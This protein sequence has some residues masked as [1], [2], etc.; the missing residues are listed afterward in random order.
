MSQLKTGTSKAG[1][2]GARG[3]TRGVADEP[4][5]RFDAVGPVVQ[6]SRLGVVLTD[7]AEATN[8]DAAAWSAFERLISV[9]VEPL[10]LLEELADL[11]TPA[12]AGETHS[13]E[14]FAAHLYRVGRAVGSIAG[15]LPPRGRELTEGNVGGCCCCGSHSTAGHD[16]KVPEIHYDG[17]EVTGRPVAQSAPGEIFNEWA[18]TTLLVAAAAMAMD[19]PSGVDLTVDQATNTI[20]TLA[21]HSA[22]LGRMVRGHDEGGREGLLGEL[23]TARTAGDLKWAAAN[24]GSGAAP[25]MRTMSGGAPGGFEMPQMPGL[26]GDFGLPGGFPGGLEFPGG[27]P[28]GLESPGGR[29]PFIPDPIGELI[30]KT[31]E[32]FREPKVWDPERYDHA[33]PFWRDQFTYH[34]PYDLA[35]IRCFLAANKL[36]H[37]LNEP[38]PVPPVRAVWDTGITSV[39]IAGACGGSKITIKGSSFGATRPPDTVLLL[40]TLDGCRTVEPTSWSDKRIE[41]VLPVRVASGSVGFGDRA[42]IAAYDAWA[43]RMNDLED[44]LASLGCAPRPI[45]LVPPFGQCP[46]TSTINYITAGTPEIVAFTANDETV[47]VLGIGQPLT[48]RWTVKNAAAVQIVRTSPSGAPFGGSTTLTPFLQTSYAFGPQSHVSIGEWT[49]RIS[50][51]G[52]CGGPISRTVTVVTA[53]RPALKVAQ[54]QITQSVQTPDHAVK[55]VAFKPTVVR[56]LVNHGLGTWGGGNVPGVSGRIRLYRAPNWSPWIDAA[57]NTVPM[58]ATPGTTITVPVLPAMNRTNDTLNFILPPDWCWGM[59]SYQIDVRVSGF[60]ATPSFA[61]YTEGVSRNTPSVTYANRRTLQFRYIRVNWNGMGAPTD[62][63]CRNTLAAAVPLL[64]TPSAGIAP[65]PGQGIHDRSSSTLAQENDQRRDMLDDFE[66]EHDCSFWEAAT[67]WLGSDCPDDDGAIWVLIPGDF[68]RGEAFAIP[69][70]V[71]FTPPNDGPYAAHEIAHCLDQQ[72]VRL[73]PPGVTA[74][75]GGDPSSAWP[76]NGVLTDVPFDSVRNRVL[77]AGGTGVGDVMTYWGTPENTWPMPR[78]WQQLWDYIG[79]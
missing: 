30:A 70:N 54:V 43:A 12:L 63:V 32:R 1:R 67:E 42:Y 28:G 39:R 33:Y 47:H 27:I 68:R 59:V 53:K 17:T 23:E 58:Q 8:G 35:N 48:L 9:L 18:L 44:Q 21:L 16:S 40:P 29:D 37:A 56:V 73:A 4:N 57:N 75:T 74:P 19:A 41:A 69:S 7:L 78:R 20:T 5:E 25:V 65:V 51:T 10:R 6:W 26:P 22:L 15:T 61:G 60:G 55:L 64:P 46:P 76:N 66:D 49:Y 11:A 52:A 2:K 34:D 13:R 36:I 71:C 62:D 45:R 24:S 31:L 50:A 72:H 77:N 79:P 38:P 14:R 3:D